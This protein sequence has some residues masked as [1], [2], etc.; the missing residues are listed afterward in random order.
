MTGRIHKDVI[1]YKT[2]IFV[3]K[4]QD[5]SK[6]Y[7]QYLSEKFMFSDIHKNNWKNTLLW[8]P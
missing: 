7:Q 4:L 5:Y 2:F 8:I 1:C 6:A 3:L